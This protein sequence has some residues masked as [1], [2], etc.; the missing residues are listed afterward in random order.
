METDSGRAEGV[1][2]ICG[3]ARSGTSMCRHLL[4]A[5]P[6][7]YVTNELGRQ[8]YPEFIRWLNRVDRLVQRVPGGSYRRRWR[9]RRIGVVRDM[10]LALSKFR[11]DRDAAESALLV[12][13][14]TPRA[15]LY[16]N[17]L[18]RALAGISVRYVY[19]LRDPQKVLR[20]K[21]NMALSNRNFEYGV[22]DLEASLR[23]MF[24]LE[25]AFP[26]R[27][28]IFSVDAYS[29]F[30]KGVVRDLLDFLGVSTSPEIIESLAG[31][32]PENTMAHQI[33]A[34][35]GA[36]ET[37]NGVRELTAEQIGAL[38]SSPIFARATAKLAEISAVYRSKEGNSHL[39]SD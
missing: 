17:E 39:L 24:E 26:E 18:E 38:A 22:K 2:Q 29:K 9:E 6:D 34:R 30:P 20:S 27:V 36:G 4:H 37:V 5:H 7:V 14:K 21:L 33:A 8:V 12:G 19:C 16:A 31:M 32:S 13:N 11:E 15:E 25:R 3:Y 23:K 10:W 28:Y 35:R 1:V